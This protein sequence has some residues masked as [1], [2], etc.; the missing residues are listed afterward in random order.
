M[1]RFVLGFVAALA[2]AIPTSLAIASTH[3]TSASSSITWPATCELKTSTAARWSCV[4]AH[5]NAL[6]SRQRAT[7]ALVLSLKSQVAKLRQTNARVFSCLAEFPVTKRDM[8]DNWYYGSDTNG[9]GNFDTNNYGG[10]FTPGMLEQTQSGWGVDDW[11]VWD[12]CSTPT[13]TRPP[14]P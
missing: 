14:A 3:N 8:Y 4:D 7:G 6:D 1:K 12:T 13:Y 2:A 5:L 10:Q 11:L 9:D